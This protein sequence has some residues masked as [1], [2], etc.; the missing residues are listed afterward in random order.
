MR[1]CILIG[2]KEAPKSISDRA[3]RVCGGTG[4]QLAEIMAQ[5]GW[6]AHTVRGFI[7]ILGSKAGLTVESSESASGERYYKIR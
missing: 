6:Q 4:S 3:P 7:S 1:A 2:P 5:T